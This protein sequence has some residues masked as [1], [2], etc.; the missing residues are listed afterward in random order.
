VCF[1]SEDA[2]TFHNGHAVYKQY[3]GIVLAADEGEAIAKALYN[4]E[5]WASRPLCHTQAW[6]WS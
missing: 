5:D 1:A 6:G 3:K 2:F 4:K